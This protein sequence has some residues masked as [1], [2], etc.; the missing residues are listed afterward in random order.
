MIHYLLRC[1]KTPQQVARILGVSIP[2]LNKWYKEWVYPHPK[3]KLAMPQRA[4]MESKH[5]EPLTKDDKHRLVRKMIDKQKRTAKEVA[6]I[7]QVTVRTIER[8]YKDSTDKEVCRTPTTTSPE[9]NPDRRATMNDELKQ[10][11]A[12]AMHDYLANQTDEGWAKFQIALGCYLGGLDVILH[13][14][15]SGI[16][17]EERR[18]VKV[19]V[20]GDSDWLYIKPEGYGE[21]E[22][23]NGDG[24]PVFL[25]LIDN[26]LRL[27]YATDIND[28]GSRES[29]S[30]EGAR[31][32]K[33]DDNDE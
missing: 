4:I 23:L 20:S 26:E 22:A 5:G 9:H 27:I 28:D 2:T 19:N 6:D 25:E 21:C 13:E 1:K 7:L 12:K 10:K 31:E 30:L 15:D 14:K 18:K 11:R 24:S 33:R 32:D 17:K 8:W 3:K 16:P 29:L